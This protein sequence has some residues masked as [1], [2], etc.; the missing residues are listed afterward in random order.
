MTTKTACGDPLVFNC[1]SS[2]QEFDV[3][4]VT[5]NSLSYTYTIDLSKEPNL[6]DPEQDSTMLSAIGSGQLT[7]PQNSP[8][9]TFTAAVAPKVYTY[10]DI[11]HLAARITRLETEVDTW[12]AAAQTLSA[13]NLELRDQTKVHAEEDPV[14]AYERAMKAVR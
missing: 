1:A 4:V 9:C 8:V 14:I 10:K 12:K 13:I 6:L 5:C 3:N 2:P 11:E 7:L